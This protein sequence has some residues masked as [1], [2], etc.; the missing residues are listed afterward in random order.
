MEQLVFWILIAFFFP[1]MLTLGI[2]LGGML[3]KLFDALEDLIKWAA[4]FRLY[5]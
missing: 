1:I 3:A 2:A 5:K 4:G